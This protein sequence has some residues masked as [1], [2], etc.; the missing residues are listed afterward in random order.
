MASICIYGSYAVCTI[1]AKLYAQAPLAALVLNFLQHLP[2]VHQ[3][4]SISAAGIVA[5]ASAEIF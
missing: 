4:L 3:K 1:A 5:I 2:F